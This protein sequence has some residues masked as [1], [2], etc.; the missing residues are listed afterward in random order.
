MLAYWLTGVIGRVIRPQSS[1]IGRE[2]PRQ[3]RPRGT[4]IAFAN[5]APPRLAALESRHGKDA[6]LSAV[7]VDKGRKDRGWRRGVGRIR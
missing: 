2:A 6:A 7:G 4:R 1:A 5:A 3:Y